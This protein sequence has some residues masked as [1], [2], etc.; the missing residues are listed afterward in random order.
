MSARD[1]MEFI[2]EQD[3]A[4]LE[5][6]IQRLEFRAG[7]PPSSATGT[8]TWTRWTWRPARTCWISAAGQGW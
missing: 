5:R 1:V 7:T 2:N 3:E 4:T 8:P 6:F